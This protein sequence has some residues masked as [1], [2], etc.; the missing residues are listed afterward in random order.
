[1]NIR[2]QGSLLVLSLMLAFGLVFQSQAA[3]YPAPIKYNQTMVRVF[4]ESQV[5]GWLST[6]GRYFPEMAVSANGAKI[7]FTVRIESTNDKRLYVANADG[8]GLMDVTGSVPAGKL[9][10]DVTSLR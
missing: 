3:S 7:G 5:S 9:P 6:Y 2:K 1:M 8:T 10:K 4:T